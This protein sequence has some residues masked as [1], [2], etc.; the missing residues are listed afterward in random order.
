[1]IKQNSSKEGRQKET[2]AVRTEVHF[3][4]G[5]WKPPTNI[6]ET[7]DEYIIVMEIPGIKESDIQI[8][9]DKGKIYL[10]GVREEPKQDKLRCVHQI[11]VRYGFFTAVAKIGENVD[12]SKTEKNYANGFLYVKI[13][14]L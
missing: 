5:V 14:K 4:E 1:M 12:F 6:F 10:S 13:P 7:L 3:S 11:E 9:Y 2:K 8:K